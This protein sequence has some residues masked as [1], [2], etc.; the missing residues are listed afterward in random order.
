[1]A[2]LTPVFAI[3]LFSAAELSEASAGIFKLVGELGAVGILGWYCWYVT[4]KAMPG[5]TREYREE[6]A[7]ERRESAET[8]R[9]YREETAELRAHNEAVVD[10]MM[11]KWGAVQDKQHEDNVEMVKA[12]RE[13]VIKVSECSSCPDRRPRDDFR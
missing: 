1:V 2:R 10:R 8:R 11:A 6:V 7:A 12:I 4:K 9:V 3:I 13:L 5:L